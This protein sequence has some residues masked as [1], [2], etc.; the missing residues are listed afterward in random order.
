MKKLT[1]IIAIFLLIGAYMIVKDKD[2]D[3]KEDSQDRVS[4]LKDFTGWI[5]NLGKNVKDLGSEAKD[6]EWLP[7]EYNETDKIE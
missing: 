5:T 4:F 6:Q 1:V 2:Y 7:Q 3:L